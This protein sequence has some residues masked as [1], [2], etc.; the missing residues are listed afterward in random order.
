MSLLIEPFKKILH[1]HW[2][3][4]STDSQREVFVNTALVFTS[5]CLLFRTFTITTVLLRAI[6]TSDIWKHFRQCSVCDCGKRFGIS[7]HRVYT[8]LEKNIDASQTN[9]V[10]KLLSGAINNTS[11]SLARNFGAESLAARERQS[12]RCNK[13][14]KFMVL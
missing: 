14:D 3:I 12:L 10:D 5:E 4:F 8:E 2:L 13:V 1:C 7:T 9:F 6:S 11:R